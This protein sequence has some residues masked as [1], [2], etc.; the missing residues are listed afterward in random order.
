[1]K[2]NANLR[3]HRL[4]MSTAETRCCST[5]VRNLSLGIVWKVERRMAIQK[6]FNECYLRA[7]CMWKYITGEGQGR[8]DQENYLF[9]FVDLSLSSRFHYKGFGETA[10]HRSKYIVERSAAAW[11]ISKIKLL[12]SARKEAIEGH[13]F[14]LYPP[15]LNFRSKIPL[16]GFSEQRKKYRGVSIWK[17]VSLKHHRALKILTLS[18]NRGSEREAGSNNNNLSTSRFVSSPSS[19][20]FGVRIEEEESVQNLR[21][22]STQ[23]FSKNDVTKS[24]RD[25]THQRQRQKQNKLPQCPD[26]LE[27]N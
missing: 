20:K 15:G 17:R 4:M 2:S 12:V 19:S 8:A 7:C 11:Q 5:V 23:R 16:D 14:G 26:I 24:L 13:L 3:L 25:T 22:I 27:D 18:A 1:M 21:K 10:E 6:V 9:A